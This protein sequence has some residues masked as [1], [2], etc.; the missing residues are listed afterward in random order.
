L[1]GFVKVHL[2]PEERKRV[3][4]I[5]TRRDFSYFDERISD[6]VVEGGLY[7]ISLGFSSRELLH[8][9]EVDIRQY[10]PKAIP[11]TADTMLGDVLAS[12]KNA[13]L[14]A[15]VLSLLPFDLEGEDKAMMRALVS[16][17]PIRALVPW[18]H[19]V[20][21]EAMMDDLVMKLQKRL[22]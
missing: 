15:P 10:M 21:S 8:T 22:G 13:D 20:F 12:Q 3:Q 5:L 18:S 2:L 17:L 11:I 14:L 19:G 9:I 1:K 4:F 16:A 6:W 7:R